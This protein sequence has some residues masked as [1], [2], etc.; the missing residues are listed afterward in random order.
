MVLISAEK[1]CRAAGAKC[2]RPPVSILELLDD[3]SWRGFQQHVD[4]PTDKRTTISM[5]SLSTLLST[6]RPALLHRLRQPLSALRCE[7]AS[8]PSVRGGRRSG[9]LP[10]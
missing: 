5:E 7:A 3:S 9:G 1:L 10:F 4:E 2:I 8:S 6:F